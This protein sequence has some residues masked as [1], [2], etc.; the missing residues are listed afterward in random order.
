[1][2]RDEPEEELFHFRVGFAL[3]PHDRLLILFQNLPPVGHPRLNF[4]YVILGARVTRC[5][6]IRSLLAV[7]Q[8]THAF[9]NVHCNP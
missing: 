4:D 7:V 8:A 3:F 2:R 9:D 5:A 6:V 1:M